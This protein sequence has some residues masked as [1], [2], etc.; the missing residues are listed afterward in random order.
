MWLLTTPTA[1]R[2]LGGW[3]LL[4]TAVVAT[5]ATNP[6]GV[7]GSLLLLL[8]IG[9]WLVAAVVVT[10]IAVTRRPWATLICVLTWLSAFLLVD[11]IVPRVS[12]SPLLEDDLWV[13]FGA[14]Y[15]LWLLVTGGGVWWCRAHPRS[16]DP[17]TT[18][19][20]KP[21]S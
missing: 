16:V 12:R 3:L 5:A 10:A 21:L 20:S 17:R 18:N 4:G 7:L 8:L 1:Y 15:G 2:W 14:G 13:V 19:T 6:T 9:V 11:V